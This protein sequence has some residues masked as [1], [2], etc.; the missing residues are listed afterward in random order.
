MARRYYVDAITATNAALRDTQ[1]VNNDSTIIAVTL[2]SWFERLNW[3]SDTSLHSWKHHVQGAT[4]VL[5]MRGQVGLRTRE[6]LEIFREVRAHAILHA[7]LAEDRV[8]EF[9]VQWSQA[10]DHDTVQS[11]ADQLAIIACRTALIRSASKTGDMTD[12]RLSEMAEELE[13]D[14]VSWSDD[15]SSSKSSEALRRAPGTFCW[16]DPLGACSC[17]CNR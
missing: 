13:T 2:L 4:Q 8:P 5:Q 12:E 1:R 9:I 6:G 15:C 14:L 10:L 7:L 17:C 3:E 16:H 11:P